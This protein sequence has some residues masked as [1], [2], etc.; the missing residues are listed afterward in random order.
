MLLDSSHF[1]AKLTSLE[2]RSVIETGCEAIREKSLHNEFTAT[3]LHEFFD[4]LNEFQ[5]L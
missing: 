2:K 3:S 4:E 1:Y 5:Q